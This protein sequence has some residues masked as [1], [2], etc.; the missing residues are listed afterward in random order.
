[1]TFKL[2]TCQTGN[3]KCSLLSKLIT[4]SSLQTKLQFT[5]FASPRLFPLTPGSCQAHSGKILHQ[6]SPTE[7]ARSGAVLTTCSPACWLASASIGSGEGIRWEEAWAHSSCH[8]PRTLFKPPVPSY[9]PNRKR[10]ILP[11]PIIF[12]LPPAWPRSPF[13]LLSSSQGILPASSLQVSSRT[14]PVQSSLEGKHNLDHFTASSETVT[15][16]PVLSG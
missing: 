3:Q 10:W 16:F 7:S 15:V 14:I 5:L 11:F 8:L 6:A 4:L 1:M 2:F 12:L 13:L 9:L